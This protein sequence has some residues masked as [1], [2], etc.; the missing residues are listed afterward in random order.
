MK[1]LSIALSGAIALSVS[2]NAATIHINERLYTGDTLSLMDEGIYID[3]N[4]IETPKPSES[5]D[6]RI[7]IE[8]QLSNLT[9]Y[10]NI[11]RILVNGNVNSISTHD[12]NINAKTVGT[13]STVTGNITAQSILEQLNEDALTKGVA[14]KSY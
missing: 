13:A 14:L 8:G 9:T 7:Y 4:L 12:G 5:G 10:K 3:D 11:D 2:A 6:I 1:L